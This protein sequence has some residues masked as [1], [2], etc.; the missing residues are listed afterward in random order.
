MPLLRHAPGERVQIAGTYALVGHYG[1]ALGFA[2]VFSK[3]DSFPLVSASE[4]EPCWYVL[5]DV[6]NSVAR[7]A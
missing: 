6:S 7:A 4:Y 3:G 1:E 5:V 2:R